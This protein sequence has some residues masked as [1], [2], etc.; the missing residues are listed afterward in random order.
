MTCPHC[1]AP[2][3]PTQSFCTSCGKP[4]AAVA[5]AAPVPAQA[6]PQPAP[7]LHPIPDGG[8][9]MEEIVA[10]LQSGGYSAKVFTAD[11]GK[12][13]ILSNAHGTPYEIHM[14]G[15]LSG[16]CESIELVAAFARNG[17]FD[18]SK[19]NEWNRDVPWCKTYYDGANDPS[20][21]MD[22]ALSPG[23]TYESLNDQF[24]TWITVLGRFIKQYDLR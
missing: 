17:K 23:G 16:R 22:I 12:R 19:L 5:A 21:D 13:R 10:W 7:T 14:P 2:S 9:T 6:A 8:L 24:S 18:V 4:L 1:G 3:L 11:N 20:I 15:C